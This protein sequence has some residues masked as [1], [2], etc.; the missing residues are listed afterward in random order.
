MQV[1]LVLDGNGPRLVGA[2]SRVRTSL[3]RT[4]PLVIVVLLRSKAKGIKELHK[5][6]SEAL[7]Q[8]RR[9]IKKWNYLEKLRALAA[10]GMT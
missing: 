5:D 2:H 10:R 8:M 6:D 4:G 3:S 7:H 9:A 1:Y